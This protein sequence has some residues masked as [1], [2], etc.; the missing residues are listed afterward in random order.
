MLKPVVRNARV[1]TRERV[2]KVPVLVALK[3]IRGV[4]GAHVGTTMAAARVLEPAC[5]TL[6]LVAA[7]TGVSPRRLSPVNLT[8][9][10]SIVLATGVFG[11]RAPPLVVRMVSVQA[12]TSR[13]HLLRMV[14]KN[15]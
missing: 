5:L 7:I 15:V 14:E 9:A 3:T 4:N 8:R 11:V 6:L 2:T 13:T 12:P 1:R 10:R